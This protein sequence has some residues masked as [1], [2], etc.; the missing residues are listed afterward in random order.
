MGIIH[1]Y[2]ISWSQCL[3]TAVPRVVNLT[4]IDHIA[5]FIIN[6][7]YIV[8]IHIHTRRGCPIGDIA[9]RATCSNNTLFIDRVIIRVGGIKRASIIGGYAISIRY[10][11][12]VVSGI[13]TITYD[14]VLVLRV[15]GI[16]TRS[17]RMVFS[18]L[19]NSVLIGK[20]FCHTS[21]VSE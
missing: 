10:S 11:P 19:K 6:I 4:D 2:P 8:S 9:V 5:L 3:F 13:G 16:K 21:L 15:T 17:C 14:T 12:P 20:A 18:T 7:S 1:F